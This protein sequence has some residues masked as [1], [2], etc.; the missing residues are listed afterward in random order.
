MPF[1]AKAL[2]SVPLCE[3]TSC[4]HTYD[5]YNYVYATENSYGVL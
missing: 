3:E 2:L 4:G 1:L 5:G